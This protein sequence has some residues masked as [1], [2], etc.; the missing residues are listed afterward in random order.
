M[1]LDR[2]SLLGNVEPSPG[3]KRVGNSK[4]MVAG[5]FCLMV[6]GAGSLGGC[7]QTYDNSAQVR[8]A[9]AQRAMV[10]KRARD[11]ESSRVPFRAGVSTVTVENMARQRGCTGGQG[12]GLTTPQGPVELYRMQCSNGQVFAALCEFRQCK[13]I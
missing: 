5:L 9:S 2:I 3:E 8:A 11:A 13:A 1:G 7:A 4:M 10:V 12:A 6:L